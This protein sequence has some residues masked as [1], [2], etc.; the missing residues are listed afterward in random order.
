MD[1]AT[2][3]NKII[4]MLRHELKDVEGVTKFLREFGGVVIK[5]KPM[6]TLNILP[7]SLPH[8]FLIRCNT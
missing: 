2:I 4:I 3:T 1:V 6:S 8:C 5:K 7:P